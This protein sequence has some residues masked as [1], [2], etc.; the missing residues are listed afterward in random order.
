MT[1]VPL[2]VPVIQ[3][4]T[5]ICQN[6]STTL[7][8]G[9][10]FAS[11]KWSNGATTQSIST[12]QA[13]T[14]TV[15]VTNAQGCIGTSSVTVTVSSLPQP[16]ISGSL[17]IC[18]GSSTILDAGSGFASYL[19][20]TG[21][22][23]HSI[24]ATQAGTY[25]ATVTNAAGCTGAT[26]ATAVVNSLPQPS[27][28]GS[29]SFC[30]GNSTTLNAGSG[31][32]SYL[33]SNGATTQNITATQAGTYTVTVTNAQMCMGTTSATVAVNPLPQPSISGS[34]SF[35]EGGSTTLN[36]GSSFTSYLWSNGATTQ[37]ITATQA[38]TYTVTV[39]NT[40][41]CFGTS[42]VAVVVNPLPQPNISGSLSFCEGSSTML[43]AGSGF[44]SYLWEYGATTQNITTP[45]AGTYTVTVKNTQGCF[46]TSS[47]AVVVN[48]LPQPNISGSLS[49]C[50]GSST[51]LNAGV[52]FRLI[53][54]STGQPRKTSRSHKWERTPLR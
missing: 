22:T 32:T 19:W 47:V 38:G 51:M 53:C 28:S 44:S 8:A 26:S 24:S 49:F 12:T 5:V 14:Y 13:G 11:Y 42:S 27:V 36:A 30:A 31:F 43:N 45:Q 16:S 54:G 10:G 46:G 25:S 17:N 37:N 52:I 48:P 40:Q 20:S 6:G 39:K 21:A 3:G 18:Q 1:A 29:L 15:S 35:C 23:T 7:S 4:S 2:P 41:G 34:L 9:I 33:W 50:E